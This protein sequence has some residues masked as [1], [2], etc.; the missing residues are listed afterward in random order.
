MPAGAS[1]ARRLFPNHESLPFCYTSRVPQHVSIL[2]AC[3]LICATASAAQVPTFQRPPVPEFREATFLG[4]TTCSPDPYH[5]NCAHRGDKFY[6]ID[7]GGKS[8]LLHPTF[9]LPILTMAHL[10]LIPGNRASIALPGDN[11]LAHLTPGATFR[12]HLDDDGVD[13]R[14][15]AQSSKGPRYLASRY[16][17]VAPA[18]EASAD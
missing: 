18:A 12:I 13:V 14:I 15:L 1:R 3:V 9:S 2:A 8:Y 10:L 16:T 4:A 5:S 11:V 17:F 7:I 6:A